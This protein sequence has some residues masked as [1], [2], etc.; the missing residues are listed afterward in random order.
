MR[1]YNTSWCSHLPL[2]LPYSGKIWRALNLVKWQKKAVFSYWQ[3]LNLAICNYLWCNHFTLWR[4]RCAFSA[5]CTLARQ[6]WEWR[7]L[8]STA[9]FEATMFSKVFGTQPQ[10]K[11]WTACEKGQTPRILTLWLWYVKRCCWPRPPKDVSCL[12]GIPKTKEDY[13]IWSTSTSIV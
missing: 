12:C 10:G 7:L 2:V 4:N 1:V 6:N 8:K 9:A 11:N 3:N 5:W 13:P